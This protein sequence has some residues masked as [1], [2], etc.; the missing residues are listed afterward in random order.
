[1]ILTIH[2][3]FMM[4]LYYTTPTTLSLLSHQFCCFQNQDLSKADENMVHQ[5][6]DADR[7]FNKKGIF[8]RKMPT[9][10]GNKKNAAKLKGYRLAQQSRDIPV[11]KPGDVIKGHVKLALRK[12]LEA[13]GFRIV[14]TGKASVR[15]NE[16]KGTEKFMDECMILW[17]RAKC[18]ADLRE[19][20]ITENDVLPP[21]DRIPLGNYEFPFAF[22]IP[23]TAVSSCPPLF[24]EAGSR[25]YIV[26][27]LMAVVDRNKLFKRGNIL[28]MQGLWVEQEVDVADNADDLELLVVKKSF[29]P[30]VFGISG[31]LYCTAMLPARAFVKDEKIDLYLEISNNTALY[32]N[33]VKALVTLNGKAKAG[34]GLFHET[35]EVRCKSEK[36]KC[37]M[38]AINTTET[39]KLSLVVDFRKR[40]IDNNLL[41]FCRNLQN[42]KLI[43]L[44][45]AIEIKF[46]W[47]G[48]R[49]NM[50]MKIP[51]VL[52]SNN[53]AFFTYL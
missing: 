43:D 41:P 2:D 27:R 29:K 48:L 24:D 33:E 19:K 7:M 17:S 39:C 36:E 16:R 38:I 44:E 6:V 10:S 18:R 5:I 51:I 9:K 37:G 4:Y 45:Y 35:M 20:L 23:P 31:E 14:A 15:E 30:R 8:E 22:Q 12:P 34:N 50:T 32:I 21:S 49:R 42:C 28:A 25:F 13:E 46:K 11:Y 52:G 3:V 26:Y 1:M 53:S 40:H 47:K